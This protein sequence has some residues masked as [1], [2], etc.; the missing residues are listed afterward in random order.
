[1][2]KSNIFQ[3]DKILDKRVENLQQQYKLQWANGEVGWEM[4]YNVFDLAE[5][6]KFENS[7]QQIK[8]MERTRRCEIRDFMRQFAAEGWGEDFDVTMEEAKEEAE[9][10]YRLEFYTGDSGYPYAQFANVW[11]RIVFLR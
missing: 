10:L 6:A 11:V 3:F 8:K 7:Y 5:I 1:M 2:P 4:A 9:E